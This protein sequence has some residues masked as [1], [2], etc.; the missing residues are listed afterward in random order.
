MS[1]QSIG[2][3]QVKM[4]QLRLCRKNRNLEFRRKRNLKMIVNREGQ[5]LCF[6][7]DYLD[8][9]ARF[10]KKHFATTF[11]SG[12]VNFLPKPRLLKSNLWLRRKMNSTIELSYF[13]WYLSKY[14]ESWGFD[15]SSKNAGFSCTV[16]CNVKSI[17]QK[18][19][20]NKIRRCWVNNC[21][22]LLIK[23]STKC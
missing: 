21:M 17:Q 19:W 10:K 1:F 8:F 20:A 18:C 2:T 4:S 5:Q 22:W 16:F 13:Y 9:Y 12:S 23:I 6:F 11:F 14:L 7:L 3:L 15:L